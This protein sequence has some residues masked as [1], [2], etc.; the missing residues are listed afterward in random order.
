V[1]IRPEN[2]CLSPDTWPLASRTR[3]LFAP[4]PTVI[5]FPAKEAATAT[6]APAKGN[7]QG[8]GG[9]I[10]PRRYMRLPFPHIR[11]TG[12]EKSK[13]GLDKG[14]EIGYTTVSE[15]GPKGPNMKAADKWSKQ[16]TSGRGWGISRF[17]ASQPSQTEISA[18]GSIG[19]ND[20]RVP[21]KRCDPPSACQCGHWRRSGSGEYTASSDAADLLSLHER[22]VRSLVCGKE[23]LS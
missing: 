16:R 14:P 5:A 19:E 22:H 1:V 13:K 10:R 8:G 11:Y 4:N 2:P 6:L 7:G 9:A 18:P 17:K 20:A 12:K 21:Q 15:K 3:R 23:K